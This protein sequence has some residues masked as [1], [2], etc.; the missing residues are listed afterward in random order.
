[1]YSLLFF[2]SVNI[3]QDFHLHGNI[4]TCVLVGKIRTVVYICNHKMV[5]ARVYNNG[6]KSSDVLVIVA[7]ATPISW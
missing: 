6:Q 3:S 1:M 7:L 2:T 5:T 4:P